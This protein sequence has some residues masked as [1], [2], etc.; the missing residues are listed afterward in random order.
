[1]SSSLPSTRAS[2]RTPALAF[3]APSISA[4]AKSL[5]AQLADA[6]TTPTHVQMLNLLARAAGHRNY[7][8]FRAAAV[9]A[10][11]AP[12]PTPVPA[13]PAVALSTHATK[14]RSHF[15][16]QGRLIRWPSRYAVQRFAIWSLWLRFDPKRQ[17]TEREVN[18]VLN[19]WATFG[20]PVTLRRELINM[21]L[22]ARKPNGAA[23]WKQAQ[24]P[25][26]D[27][28]AFLTTIRHASAEG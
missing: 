23:Y 9:L 1:M 18:A 8:A 16:E 4:L 28:Q 2:S 10:P 7:Q 6:P 17:Y 20:D 26:P 21:K 12:P 15:D 11:V 19:A 27:V 13:A 24:R 3:S 25:E 5:C 22:L 14:A